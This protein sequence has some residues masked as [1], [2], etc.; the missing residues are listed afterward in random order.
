MRWW[1]DRKWKRV[2][3]GQAPGIWHWLGD[4]ARL[5]VQ[6]SDQLLGFGRTFL[7]INPKT[8]QVL[9]S[10]RQEEFVDGRG[11]CLSS[12]VS[13]STCPSVARLPRCQERE[14]GLAATGKRRCSKRS[15]RTIAPRIRRGLRHV[16]LP[17][18]P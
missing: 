1:A 10:A 4:V 2:T 8:K 11:T 5:R 7:A 9:W 16:G 13:S 6:E 14:A 3:P 17:E 18:S 12:G 15:A